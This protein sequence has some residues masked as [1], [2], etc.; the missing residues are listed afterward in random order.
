M[1]SS[2]R[3]RSSSPFSHRKPAPS[4]YSS[5]SS[6]SSYMSSS[7]RLMPRSCSSSASSYYN[8]I[9]GGGGG[10]GGYS[11]ARSMTPSR[12]QSDSMY[13]GSS[14]R[15]GYGGSRTP[16]PVGY[17]SEELLAAESLE[18]PRS[19]ESISVT[20][21]FRP[22][23][24]REFQ[25]GDEIAW[26][27]DGDKMVR[28]EY[29]PAS[30][31]AFDKVFGPHTITQDV[32]DIAAKPV[33]K[34]AM[35][36]INGTVFAYGVTS[37]GKTF[38]MHGDQSAPGIIPLAIKD[39]FSMIQD[40][41]GREFLLRVSYLEI[42][43]EVINDL[44]DPTGQN[45]RVREDAQGTYVEGIKEEVVLSPGHALSFI[46]AGEEHR[47]VGSNNFNL[48][49]S[50]SHTIFT[51]MIESSAHGD[52][53]DGVVFSQLNL[54][55]LAGSESSKTETTGLRRKEGAY[56]NKSLLT[57]GTVIGKL[58]EGRASHVPYRDSKLT[59]LLQSSLSGHGH[60]SLICTVTPASS[61]LEETHN[62][63]K[64]ASRAKRVEIYAS[65]NKIID[66]K[67][68]IKKYQRE[69][70]TL[71][72]EL[73]Q[74]RSGMVVG[75]SHEEILSLKQ[76]LEEGQVK[77]QSRLEEEEEAKAALMSRIQRLTKLIL[78]STKNSIP[79]LGDVP[80]HHRS[81]SD[82]KL[83]VL[84]DG[85]LL[86]DSE[87][88]NSPSSVNAMSSDLSHE[89][90]LRRSS[91]KWNEELSPGCSAVA[92]STAGGLELTQDQM[93]LLVEQVKM[94]AGEI[95]LGTSTMKRLVEQ[96]VTDPEN[97]KPQIQNLER[98]IQEKRRQMRALEQ[99]IIESGEASIANGSLVDM[100]QT[101]MRL[102]TQHNEKAFELEIKSAD[103][104]ILQEQLQ[105]KCLENKELQEKV[106]LLEQHL[107][108]LSGDKSSL[109]SSQSVPE[110]FVDE[111]KKKIQSQEISNE[112][113]KIH[114]VQ[115]SEDNSGLRVQNQK[116]AEEA[117]YA[118]ELA[119]AAAVEL[120]NLAGEV[121]K[122]SLQNAKLEKELLAARESLHSRGAAQ[123]GGGRNGLRS[124]RKGRF[125]SGRGP[126]EMALHSDDFD[127]WD[128]DPND[129]RME[130][131]ARK[132]REAALEAALA[133]KE[134]IEH[135]YR[136]R[137][138]EARR[139]EESLENDLANMWVLVAKLKKDGGNVP[140][141][142]TDERPIDTGNRLGEPEPNGFDDGSVLKE[143]QVIDDPKPAD[144]MPKEEPLVLRLKARMQ[145]MKEKELKHNGN[146]DANSHICKCVNPAPLLV[147]SAQSAEQRLQIGFLH[148]LLENIPGVAPPNEDYFGTS[149]GQKNVYIPD[150]Q[151]SVAYT[152][153][154]LVPECKIVQY[155]K[156]QSKM[157]KQF[158]SFSIPIIIFLVLLTWRGHS[159]QISIQ[160]D[161]SMLSD[162]VT[163]GIHHQQQSSLIQMPSSS[164]SSNAAGCHETYGFLPCTQTV[165]GNVFLIVVYGYLM[166]LA[167]KLLSAGSE[168]LLQ[169]LGP[170][171]V[172]GLFLPVLGSL[173]DAAII[174]ASG[175]SGSKLA[176]QSQV[177]VGMGLMAGSNVMLLTVLWGSCL[178]VGKLDITASTSTASGNPRTLSLTELGVAT[179]I[180]TCY[181]ARIMLISLLPFIIVQLPQ[182]FNAQ[183]GNN[184]AVVV[185]L[186]VAICMLI[187][188]SL[189]QEV[190]F[191][192]QASLIQRDRLFAIMD[193]N[194]DGYLTANE[195]RAL[196]IGIQLE[197]RHTD[198]DD[199]VY[200]VLK[201]FDTSHDTL[202]DKDEFTKGVSK[203]LEKAKNSAMYGHRSQ[204]LK[205]LLDFEECTK[206]E[207]GILG[208]GNEGSNSTPPENML[209]DTA[210]AGLIL[211]SGTLIAALVAEPLV[212][213]VNN[214]STASR[215][216]PFFVSFVILPF[217]SSSEIVSVLIF[218]S[219]KNM[220]AASLAYSEIYG[221]VTMSNLLSLSVFLGLVYYRDLEWNFSAQV[222]I[223]L[224]VCITMGL[225]ASF[226]TKFPLWMSLVAFGLYPVS[227]LLAYVLDYVVGWA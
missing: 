224:V 164:G 131:Q 107:A 86:M 68:L 170:G 67:S 16:V 103:N 145:E 201:E 55:D 141:L 3:T 41:P 211:L 216:P 84:R 15:G 139:R 102:M 227:L 14:S 136:K 199:A 127:S 22:L 175:L 82:D 167:A 217:A 9:G 163:D 153:A 143:R 166:F 53:Y 89:S 206:N 8:S 193:E 59:R 108:S 189:Y 92:E 114:Q 220:R 168:V 46:A 200:H 133:E 210:K 182:V 157:A 99:R 116:L 26:Y 209:W 128:L 29:N 2:S 100:Q 179:D 75:V 28:N 125:S 47:H 154:S 169:I 23:S 7:N 126:N 31:Y 72:E 56:I 36:G 161:E 190:Q 40:T 27:A 174:L 33:V 83:D 137:A 151:A 44:L 54:I 130:L 18:A 204:T 221:S 58:S 215:I 73:D 13:L 88:K 115:L 171:I 112:K 212:D 194:S 129:M 20:I 202:I 87:N 74:L 184:I 77:M 109:P 4:P 32:Y 12:S 117:S 21:R 225:L 160:N 208:G 198:I 138:D 207:E 176:A 69:I 195:L 121:T 25:R 65:R 35:E 187:S 78:V 191:L 178:I 140:E 110:E 146:G 156:N 159:R 37:S 1:A 186:V 165:F 34:N 19:G 188:Y 226:R 185:S 197:E 50:R 152:G 183:N 70:S 111:L 93:D 24:E 147:R 148:L 105:N 223:I 98:E 5:T 6:A 17:G 135:E 203:W 94:L 76:K 142:S 79:G 45:L 122:L 149:V 49:S 11:G 80:A 144:E 150:V 155:E 81:L 66:E 113:L 134:I 162:G 180:W 101:V 192:T 123:N 91:S 57:L 96:S 219:K 218:A 90:K 120:K 172:G 63:L 173:P 119:S 213:A 52:E 97:S 118:K 214:F 51:L 60:V 62:T 181:G 124:G 43:N 42:Y 61:N 10:S 38:T 64:F 48:F 85:T 132:Q 39:V 30:A 71:K 158:S 222:L 196:V 177:S 104:R 205:L 95:A 106:N